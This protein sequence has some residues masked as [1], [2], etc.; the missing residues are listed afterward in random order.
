M[1]TPDFDA[2]GGAIGGRPAELTDDRR[3]QAIAALRNEL[4]R[5]VTSALER[6]Y[7]LEAVSAYIDLRTAQLG[8]AIAG[9]A[10]AA[11]EDVANDP[12]DPG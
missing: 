9:S 11:A 3:A 1:T 2:A 5:A 10:G 4:A 6:G 8:A 12:S 7:T